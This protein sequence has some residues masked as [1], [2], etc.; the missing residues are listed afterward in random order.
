MVLCYC[1]TSHGGPGRRN[2]PF[3]VHLFN[4]QLE[5]I[6][7][8]YIPDWYNLDEFECDVVKPIQ[9]WWR[10]IASKKYSDISGEIC[11]QTN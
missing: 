5:D 9:I 7:L 11:K 10:E 3:P 4:C 6:G 1:C 8:G 2:V